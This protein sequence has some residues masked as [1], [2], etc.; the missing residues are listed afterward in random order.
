MS[1]DAPKDDKKMVTKVMNVTPQM[2][3][4]W[5]EKNLNNR[6]IYNTTVQRFIRIIEQGKWELSHQGIAFDTNGK[7][8]DGQHRL[9]AIVLTGKTVLIQV[10]FNTAATTR[11][12]IDTG[13]GRS[14]ADALTISGRTAT[15]P[16][17]AALNFL[18]KLITGRGPENDECIDFYDDYKEGLLF[19]WEDCFRQK[20]VRGVTQAAVLAVFAR[21]YYVADRD[22]VLS[23]AKV[24]GEGVSESSKER[25]I[26]MLRD[27]LREPRP[28]K[29]GQG[30]ERVIYRKTERALVAFL[31]AE[32]I[33]ILYELN[34]EAFP[35][36]KEQKWAG[37]GR[38]EAKLALTER[39]WAVAQQ[40][41]E[42]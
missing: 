22:K 8:I 38:K 42:H 13:R 36:P 12:V 34:N 28:R 18:F 35:L 25:V 16:V 1:K 40:P 5:L 30:Y 33:K 20:G 14:R 23:F 10:T 19:A 26:I 17:G 29:P 7:L 15:T 21:A 41:T 37:L 39:P 27:F 31:N 2:A 24:L 9:W 6:K 11:Y 3:E 4:A 32:Q